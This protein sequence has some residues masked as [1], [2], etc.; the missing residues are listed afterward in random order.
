MANT[1][2]A[3]R[4]RV[5]ITLAAI[6]GWVDA[7]GFLVL[8]G[9]FTAHLS[10]NTARLGVELGQ[11]D[12]GLALTYAVPIVVFFCGVVAGIAYLGHRE[13]DSRRLGPL[14]G[15]ELTLLVL[16]LGVGTA[17]RDAGDLT[18]RSGAY[19]ALAVLAVA[20][21]GL[22]TAAL[23][24][25]AGVQVHTTFITGMVTNLA[26]EVVGVA[27]HDPGAPQRA[28]VHGGLVG[29]YIIGA[30]GGSALESTWA[31]WALAVPIG[32]LAALIVTVGRDRAT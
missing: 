19:Y 32:A 8:F 27:R 28:R 15:A 21:M 31:L 13:P 29:A 25:V 18:A 3:A 17:L 2:V 23:R 12:A 11:G 9:L 14:L 16:Y 20:A 6:G 10:G 22:Q 30:V 5:A 1:G 4:P 26:E 24:H 7:V